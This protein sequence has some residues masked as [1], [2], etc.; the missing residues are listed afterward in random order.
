MKIAIC[1]SGQPRYLNLGYQSLNECIIKSNL[2]HDI[3]FFIHTW[4]DKD[5]VNKFFSSAQDSQLNNVGTLLKDSDTIIKNL[6]KPKKYIIE[7]QKNFD[8]YV[9]LTESSKNAKQNNLCSLFYSMYMANNLK[10]DYETQFNFKYDLVLRTR[11]DLIYYNLINFNDYILQLNSINVPDKYFFDQESF[12]NSNKPMPDIFAF[13]NT[14]NMN[15]F[16]SVYPEFLRLNKL[17]N[18]KYGE[19]Y[20]GHWVRNENNLNINPINLQI[21]FIQRTNLKYL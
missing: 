18:P 12:N 15:I 2:E 14:E 5:D 8:K 4:Y 19:N 11:T 16:S 9:E 21:N 3:D 6:Y 7:P 20:L 10:R 1:L 17:I 13:S